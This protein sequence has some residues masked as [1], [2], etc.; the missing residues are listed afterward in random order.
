MPKISIIITCY[1]NELNIPHTKKALIENE[2]N[3]PIGTEFEYVMV[4]DGSKDNTYT[5]LQKFKAEYPDKVSLI[6]LSGNFGSPNAFLAGLKY[7]TGDC[8]ILIAA[9][10]QDPVE[11]MPKMYEYWSKGIK[12]VMGNRIDREDPFISKIFG[13]TTQYLIKR[14]ALSNLPD[15]GFDYVLFD[16]E[17]REK[18]IEI[19]EKNSNTLYLFLWLKYE[20]VAIPYKRLERKFG[21]SKWTFSKKIKFFIDSFVAFS[22]LPIRIISVSGFILGLVAIFYAL[23][24]VYNRLSGNINVE[25]WSAM[26]LVFLFVSAFQMIALGILGEYLWRTLDASRNRPNYV[27]D[28]TE[29]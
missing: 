8:N 25:G 21:K 5:E 10:L 24:I 22:F 16:K 19:N 15:G 4:D 2:R 3:F 14:F 1:Y 20:Y 27:V 23:I 18:A 12:L 7:A 6:K 17:L 13:K 28:K 26:M 9:D 11:L 29:I